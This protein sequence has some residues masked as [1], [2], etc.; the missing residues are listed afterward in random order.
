[1]RAGKRDHVETIRSLMHPI[2]LQ[3]KDDDEEED[4][5]DETLIDPE[6]ILDSWIPSCSNIHMHMS[7]PRLC[8]RFPLQSIT[9]QERAD[10][11]AV[12]HDPPNAVD[13]SRLPRHQCLLWKLILLL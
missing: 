11:V 12:R 4:D 3:Q 1:M 5:V 2:M 10:N 9:S 13:F 6:G 8:H 7:L